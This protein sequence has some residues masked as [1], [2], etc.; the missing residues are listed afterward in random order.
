MKFILCYEQLKMLTSDPTIITLASSLRVTLRN[1]DY[2]WLPHESKLAHT[3]LVMFESMYSN[4]W[5]NITLDY[6]SLT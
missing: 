2:L 1:S 3:N 4:G 6:C 5:M